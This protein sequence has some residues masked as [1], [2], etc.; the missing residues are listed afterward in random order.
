MSKPSES[1]LC[2]EDEISEGKSDSESESE[3]FTEL[4]QQ[5]LANQIKKG[6]EKFNQL[7]MSNIQ[8]YNE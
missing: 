2:E 5:K 7:I 8:I 6:I 4:Q 1:F 3:D